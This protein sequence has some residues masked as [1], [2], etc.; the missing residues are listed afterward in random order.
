MMNEDEI[1]GM[2]A[3]DD[4]PSPLDPLDD[5][6]DIDIKY[7]GQ[8]IAYLKESGTRTLKTSGKFL[9][10]D[11]RIVYIRPEGGDIPKPSLPE[12][13][14]QVE[15]IQFSRSNLEDTIGIIVSIPELND[16]V[17]YTADYLDE[18]GWMAD[19]IV[20]GYRLSATQPK[21]FHMGGLPNS[22]N[23]KMESYLRSP[24]SDYGLGMYHDKYAYTPTRTR[25]KVS[26]ILRSPRSTALI[27]KYAYNYESSGVNTMGFC[28]KFYGLK[29]VRVWSFD[30]Q[31]QLDTVVNFIP[32]YRK[33]DNQVGVYDLIADQF[34][35][36]TYSVGTSCSVSAG[37]EIP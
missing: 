6:H 24:G 36:E 5:T 12:E 2:S 7:N 29:G 1:M 35:Y 16:Y 11:I 22:N 32:C 33:S 10:S 23:Y 9:S 37:P 8:V 26:I 25:R 30:V 14:Q 17:M 21:D 13:Y 27:G 31:D 20:F 4:P 18:S 28:G 3:S 19:T 15:Y 34:Y